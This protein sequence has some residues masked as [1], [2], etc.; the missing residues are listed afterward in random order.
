MLDEYY[1]IIP[2]E[3]DYDKIKNLSKYKNRLEFEE[4]MIKYFNTNRTKRLFNKLKKQFEE[5]DKRELLRQIEHSYF[6]GDYAICIT[7][8]M[9]L[10]DGSTL[11]LLQPSSWNQHNSH[12]AVE[13]IKKSMDESFD[14]KYGYELYIETDILNNFIVKLYEPVRYLKTARDKKLLSRH[15]NSHGVMYLNNQID[16]LRLMNAL[17]YCNEIIKNSGLEEK[18]TCKKGQNNFNII[19]DN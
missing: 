5:K 3:Y 6:N 11:I 12:K 16:V 1:W 10:F 15:I 2:F 19:F 18:F 7:S 13:E 9:T 4:Y 17:Y 8:L 14:E